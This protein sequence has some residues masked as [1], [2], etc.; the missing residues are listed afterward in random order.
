[1]SSAMFGM[2]GMGLEDTSLATNKLKSKFQ[3]FKGSSAYTVLVNGGL[4]IA[5]VA[6]VQSPLMKILAPQL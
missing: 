5:G 3:L 4:F 1:M 6:F 2:K